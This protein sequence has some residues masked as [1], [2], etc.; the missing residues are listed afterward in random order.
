ML[1]MYIKH[2]DARMLAMK[3]GWVNPQT[4]RGT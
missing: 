4:P 2:L 1:Q 3:I